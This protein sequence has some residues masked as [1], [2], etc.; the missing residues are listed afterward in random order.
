MPLVPAAAQGS[1]PTQR[2]T[3]ARPGSWAKPVPLQGVP[4]LHEIT[5]TLYRSAQPE[6]GGFTALEQRGI[7]TILSLRANHRDEPLAKGTALILLRVPINTWNIREKDVVAALRH[8][9][10]AEKNGPVLLHCQHGADR[11]GM[12]SALYRILYQGWS[13]EAAIAE[14]RQGAFG[15]HAI[16][17]NIPSFIRAVDAAKLRHLVGGE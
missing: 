1:I 7:K 6:R 11:T 3:E 17:G 13:K 12:I 15:Y 10:Q 14:M 5:P 9:R 2:S 8:L 16:W 4:N